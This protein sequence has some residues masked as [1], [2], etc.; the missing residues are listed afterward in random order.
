MTL[1]ISFLIPVY[2]VQAYLDA[3]LES[4]MQAIRPGDEIVLLDDGSTDGSPKICMAWQQKQPGIVKVVRQQNQGL[5]AARNRALAEASKP[6]VYF[7]DSDDLLC[8]EAF[9]QARSQLQEHQPDILTCDAWLWREDGPPASRTR[10]SHS[11]PA[12]QL[13]AREQ[14]LAATF[15]DDFLSSSCR[16]FKRT[17]LARVGP[18]VFPVG[19]TYEDNA[20][21]PRLVADAGKIL[22][23]P[24]PIFC[25][26]IRAGSITQS[27]TLRRCV[28]QATSLAPV[29]AFLTTAACEPDT[30]RAANVLAFKHLVRAVRNAA[31]LSPASGQ[32]FNAIID[33][34]LSK[35]TLPA[36]ELLDALQAAGQRELW[37]HAKGMLQRRKRYVAAR[38]ISAHWKQFLSRRRQ[39]LSP[40]P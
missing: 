1:A 22:Y 40:H 15:R 16:I 32:S 5:S 13:I 10:V 12:G 25:Y 11:L 35:L 19:K 26:R 36:D 8:A 37:R 24:E 14:A 34:G 18:E 33:A 4:V 3:C 38:T 30:A 20:T 6:H 17:F 27:H 28:D 31:S 2:N 39:G 29:L 21:I 7:L 9:G 23:L